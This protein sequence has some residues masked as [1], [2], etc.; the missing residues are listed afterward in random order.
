MTNGRVAGNAVLLAI[1]IIIC[2]PPRPASITSVVSLISR[3]GRPSTWELL[4]SVLFFCL[5]LVCL[6][7]LRKTN[8]EENLDSQM[9]RKE[10]RQEKPVLKKTKDGAWLTQNPGVGI[11]QGSQLQAIFVRE[12]GD[13]L[14]S[15]EARSFMIWRIL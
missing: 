10:D 3:T 4:L 6:Q 1:I 9:W 14:L 12:Q 2:L 8:S 7:A 15:S 11:C 5:V 13:F